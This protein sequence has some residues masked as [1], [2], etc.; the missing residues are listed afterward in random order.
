MRGGRHS[1]S[2]TIVARITGMVDCVWEE[3]GLPSPASGRG[4]GGEG[5]SDSLVRGNS[6][7]SNQKSEIRNHN[8]PLHLGD[9]LALRSGLLE[10][11][12]DTGARVILQGPVAYEVDAAAGGRLSLGKLTAKLERKKSEVRGQRSE[13]ENQKFVV[14]TPTAVVTD[15]G[16]E[17]GVEVSPS[18]Q[19]TSH[20]YRGSVRLQAT[21]P[22]GSVCGEA[23]VLSA[24][25]SARVEYGTEQ[26]KSV[27]V[28][29]VGPSAKPVAFLREIP[30]RTIK[31]LD[32]V[33]V[34][35]G[36]DGFSGKR[37]RGIDPTTGRI[38]D[39]MRRSSDPNAQQPLS[40]DGNYHRVTQN[41]FVDG[42]FIPDG[43]KEEVQVDSAGH[44]FDGF[45]RA[46][47]RTWQPIWAGPPMRGQDYPTK[48]WGV[49]YNSPG[50]G[51]IFL[52]ASNA[53]TFDLE[54]IRRAKSRLQTAAVPRHCRKLRFGPDRG[55]RQD[56]G[57]L[58]VGRWGKLA[59]SAAKSPSPP[60][61]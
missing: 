3:A 61:P 37:G 29:V 34:L 13:P 19:T 44:T 46:D 56:H 20:V 23:R 52:H 33:D 21:L 5:G 49:E 16:T 14:R 8:S 7:L 18:G 47:K 54:A 48:L 26:G 39:S 32:L 2:S 22:D 4:A 31:T 24:N 27:P 17:F 1:P 41:P 10:I 40:S 11:T 38:V 30:K 28:I 43:T 9:R 55:R 58:G 50:H 45:R 35:A 53:I 42:V 25:Q 57:R 59:T 36:G 6:Q 60:A 15:L 51:L 12:Y